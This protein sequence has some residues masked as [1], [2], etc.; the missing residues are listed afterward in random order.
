V[1][2]LR[3]AVIGLGFG[4]RHIQAYQHLPGARVVAIAARN[5]ERLEQARLEYGIPAAYTDD[6]QLYEREDLDLVSICT[7]DRL[8]A[9]QAQR[10]LRAGVHVLCEKPIATS[11][12]EAAQLVQAVRKTGLSFMSGHNYRFVPQFARLKAMIEAGTV[13][14]RLLGESCYVQDLYAMEAR[15]PGYWRWADPQ[16]FY[17][18]GAIHNVDL[19]RWTMGEVREVHSYA[20]RGMP[21]YS[22]DDT[23]VS[24]FAFENGSIGRLLLILGARLKDK[25]R[26]ELN[27][28]GAAGSVAATLGR[29]EVVQNVNALP[30][31]APLVLPVGSGDALEL[32]IAHWVDCVRRGAPPAVDVVEGAKAVAICLAAVRSA[33]ERRPITIH[34]DFL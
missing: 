1:Q 6:A 30:G 19:L 26:F 16:D 33:R 25:F 14:D 5:A 18:G 31:K 22:L 29:S 27:V 3:A 15:G 32:E 13:G 11:L 2:D 34:P 4:R 17:L 8:H 9:E 10:A 21:F 23:Y 20:T 12:E 24:N 7:P 28:V